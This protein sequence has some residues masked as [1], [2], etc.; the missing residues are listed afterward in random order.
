MGLNLNCGF[1]SGLR[2]SSGDWSVI[3]KVLKKFINANLLFSS[4]EKFC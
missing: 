1:W 3:L 2:D 4:G